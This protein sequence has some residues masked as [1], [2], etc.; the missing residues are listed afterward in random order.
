MKISEFILELE[1]IK[2]K[3]GDLIVYAIPANK[4]VFDL[5]PVSFESVRVLEGEILSIWGEKI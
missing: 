4:N 3:E 5:R 2:E 1:K